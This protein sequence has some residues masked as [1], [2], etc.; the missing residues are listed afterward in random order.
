MLINLLS[1]A[2]KFSPKSSEILVVY[3]E[4]KGV[5]PGSYQLTIQVCDRGIG[6]GPEDMV[7]LFKPFHRSKNEAS[8]QLNPNGNGLGLS[9]CQKIA[10]AM[11]GEITCESTPG[12]GTVMNFT[13]RSTARDQPPPQ[14]DVQD[15]QISLSNHEIS[16][17]EEEK[18]DK[19]SPPS[20]VE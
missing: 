9:I 20:V 13:F 8:K 15:L 5:I 4:R 11:N 6:M 7:T 17:I 18:D 3:Q 16:D 12:E 14:Q 1:N 19:P 2:V 10:K